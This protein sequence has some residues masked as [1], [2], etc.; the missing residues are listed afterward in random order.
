MYKGYNFNSHKNA[1]VSNTH[2]HRCLQ[3]MNNIL[4]NNSRNI[5]VITVHKLTKIT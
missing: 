2:T 1:C 5:N 4:K 3:R